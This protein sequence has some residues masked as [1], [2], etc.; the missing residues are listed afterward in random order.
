VH[1]SR[2]YTAPRMTNWTQEQNKKYWKAHALFGWSPEEYLNKLEE[3]RKLMKSIKKYEK[4]QEKKQ[5][6]NAYWQWRA[7]RADAYA[8]WIKYHGYKHSSDLQERF[9]DSWT[10][11]NPNPTSTKKTPQTS[12]NGGVL[13]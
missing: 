2:Y 5:E 13:M 4:K 11:G 8:K 6:F 10:K 7:R 12:P 3:G 9:N 1:L